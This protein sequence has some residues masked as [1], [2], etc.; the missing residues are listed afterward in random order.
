MDKWKSV[1]LGN[2]WAFAIPKKWY[3]YQIFGMGGMA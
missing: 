3:L 2:I 1:A